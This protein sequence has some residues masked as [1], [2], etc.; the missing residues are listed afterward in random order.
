MP[1][2]GEVSSKKQGR[3]AELLRGPAVR[4]WATLLGIAVAILR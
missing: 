4:T 3:K 1:L 2:S